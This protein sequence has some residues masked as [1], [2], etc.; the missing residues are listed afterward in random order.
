MLT[1][2]KK[3]WS[4]EMNCSGCCHLNV[5]HDTG[6]DYCDKEE[7]GEDLRPEQCEYYLTEQEIKD[8]KAEMRANR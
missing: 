2:L 8:Y 1:K 6:F 4:V 5:E 3:N 7:Y